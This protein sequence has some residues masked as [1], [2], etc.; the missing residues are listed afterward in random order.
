MNIKSILGAA[1]A[2]VFTL[3]MVSSANAVLID[4]LDGTVLKFKGGVQK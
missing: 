1:C 2:C 4:N 3:G